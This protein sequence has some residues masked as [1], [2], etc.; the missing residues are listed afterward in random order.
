MR[1]FF[2]TGRKTYGREKPRTYTTGPRYLAR[3]C[4]GIDNGTVRT[5]PVR[6]YA[7]VDLLQE[8]TSDSLRLL[9]RLL[10]KY[11]CDDQLP[12]LTLPN[13]QKGLPVGD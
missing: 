1:G 8:V 3:K 11:S 6:H 9:F 12:T 7:R 10:R 2:A 13:L 5:T 4:D